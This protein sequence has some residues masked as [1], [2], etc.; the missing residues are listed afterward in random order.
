[1]EKV[2]GGLCQP[3]RGKHQTEDKGGLSYSIPT[4]WKGQMPNPGA[5]FRKE[6]SFLLL[7]ITPPTEEHLWRSPNSQVNNVP[8][9]RQKKLTISLFYA[10]AAGLSFLNPRARVIQSSS[11]TEYTMQCDVEAFPQSPINLGA[12]RGAQGWGVSEPWRRTSG[13]QEPLW[14][15]APGL[16]RAFI[17]QRGPNLAFL[18]VSGSFAIAF[19]EISLDTSRANNGKAEAKPWAAEPMASFHIFNWHPVLVSWKN[20]TVPALCTQSP[21]FTFANIYRKKYIYTY[22]CFFVVKIKICEIVVII[23]STHF[24]KSNAYP[25]CQI[26]IIIACFKWG[27]KFLDWSV[28]FEEPVLENTHTQKK[29]IEERK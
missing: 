4:A 20:V 22:Y 25:K 27:I 1:M 13:P 16:H 23:V 7:Q 5:L 12:G 19:L 2:P 26:F 18:T 6:G 24:L 10:M 15:P 11:V 17:A 8:K 9:T 3:H 28:A 29:K 14:A 21:A